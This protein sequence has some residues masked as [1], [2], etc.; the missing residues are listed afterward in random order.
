MGTVIDSANISSQQRS[1]AIAI[2][3]QKK[4]KNLTRIIGMVSVYHN[5]AQDAEFDLSDVDT[6]LP[7]I[8]QRTTTIFVPCEVRKTTHQSTLSTMVTEPSRIGEPA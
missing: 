3:K 1:N 6:E 7:E 4:V 5:W 2:K 8:N